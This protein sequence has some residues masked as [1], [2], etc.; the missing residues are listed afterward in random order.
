MSG[1]DRSRKGGH[2]FL[3]VK[4]QDADVDWQEREGPSGA[5]VRALD[6]IQEATAGAFADVEHFLE[7][8]V[9]A[10]VRIGH[11][12]AGG[13]RLVEVAEEADVR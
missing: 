8:T 10:V 11:D 2:G 4:C 3:P 5:E 6:V 7:A 1:D 12:G 9:A 13:G